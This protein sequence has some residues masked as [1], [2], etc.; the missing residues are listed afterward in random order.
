MVEN[1]APVRYDQLPT[2]AVLIAPCLPRTSDGYLVDCRTVF[3]DRQPYFIPTTSLRPGAE[4]YVATPCAAGS[5]LA[6]LRYSREIW[7]ESSHADIRSRIDRTEREEPIRALTPVLGSLEPLTVVDPAAPL[8]P[9]FGDVVF[10]QYA[11]NRSDKPTCLVARRYRDSAGAQQMT[12]VPYQEVADESTVYVGTAYLPADPDAGLV[13]VGMTFIPIIW[14]QAWV[15]TVVADMR[16]RT[17]ETAVDVERARKQKRDAQRATARRVG[18]AVI[19]AALEPTQNPSPVVTPA[20]PRPVRYS[21]RPRSTSQDGA[22]YL[23]GFTPT[24]DLVPEPW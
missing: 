12:F 22:S 3:P 1:A 14:F 13:V 17:R 11:A 21:I 20:P 24:M 6:D 18:W 10:F 9:P 19:K 15:A 4:V 5:K 2:G 16:A 7:Q 23:N 8:L